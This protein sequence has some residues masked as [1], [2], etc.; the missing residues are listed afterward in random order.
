MFFFEKKN[1][2]TFVCLDHDTSRNKSFLVLFFK[3]GLLAS[4]LMLA[5]AAPPVTVTGAWARASL[6]LQDTSAAYMTL[7]S[8]APDSLTGV[9]GPNGMAMLHRSTHEGGMAGM[10]DMDSLALPAGQVVTLA[11][12]GTHIMLMDLKHRLRAGDTLT[13]TLHFAHAADQS[14]SVPVRPVGATGP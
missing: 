5:A 2:K 9:T 3:K 1:Q 12:G 14:V 11:P 8:A 6:P 4:C 7:R 13:L 10:A